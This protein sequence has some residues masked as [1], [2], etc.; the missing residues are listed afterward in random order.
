[1]RFHDFLLCALNNLSRRA[2]MNSSIS[3]DKLERILYLYINV[4]YKS[5]H[6]VS[7]GK[8]VLSK[9]QQSHIDEARLGSIQNMV[10]LNNKCCSTKHQNCRFIERFKNNQR[11]YGSKNRAGVNLTPKAPIQL[12]GT[13]FISI[14]S[15]A[16]NEI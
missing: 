7:F 9:K 5:L 15:T 10:K 3:T 8:A 16:V 6:L 13:L 4:L 14:A 1:M 2:K 11:C 12:L